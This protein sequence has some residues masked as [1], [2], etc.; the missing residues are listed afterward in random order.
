[1]RESRAA[2]ALAGGHGGGPGAL[3]EAVASDDPEVAF[4]A[5]CVLARFELGLRPDTPQQI[6]DLVQLYRSGKSVARQNAIGGLANQGKSARLRVLLAL[7]RRER[8]E[9]DEAG[10]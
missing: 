2:I 9:A 4:R 6:F 1:M 5:R 3:R 8:D 7:R 10:N